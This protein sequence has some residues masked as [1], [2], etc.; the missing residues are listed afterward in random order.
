MNF[1]NP[2]QL[3]HTMKK[4]IHVLLGIA[5]A[6]FVSCDSRKGTYWDTGLSFE[7]R[8]ADLVGRMTLGEKV[9]QLVH[10]A[11]AIERLGVPA[12]N[13][14]NESLHGVAR[15]GVA[16]VF[17]QAIGMAAMWDGEG[18][19]RIADAIS[20]EARAKYQDY[21]SRG[22][23]GIYQG[24][25]FWTPNLNIFR[26]PRWG[27]GMETYGEDPYLTGELGV[28]FIRGMQGDD[29][30]YLKIIATAKH[31]TVHSGPESTRHSADVYP[32]D[33]DLAETFLPHFKRAVQDARVY[34]V[35]C[36]Y[37]R[38]RGLPC[39]GSEFLEDILR[40][41]WAFEGYIVSD[42]W[43]IR[44][45]YQENQHHVVNTPPEAAAMALHAGTDLNCGPT[46]AH[47]VEA[48]KQGLVTEQ[49]IDTAVRRVML[50]RMKVG[51]FDPDDMVP[52]TRIPID[53][54]DSEE[55]RQLALEATRKS[56]VLLRNENNL[57]P[58]T[59]QV[60]KVAV[61]GPNANDVEVMI[62]NY[63][64]FPSNPVTPLEGIR[65]KLPNAGVGFAQGA[66][67][68]ENLP[69]LEV[70]PT[71]CLYTDA[72]K[73]Q[74]GLSAEFFNNSNWEGEAAHT[75]ID[76]QISFDWWTTPPYPEMAYDSYSIRWTGVL[77]PPV[78][79]EYA[80]GA[81][82]F[83]GYRVFLDG[84]MIKDWDYG[85][86]S[87]NQYFTMM[88]KQFGR[89]SLEGGRAYELRVEYKQQNSEYAM[90]RL[91]WEPPKPNLMQEALELA[92]ASDLVILCLG[93]SPL[94]EGEAMEMEVEGFRGGDK[95]DIQLPKTQRA[96]VR[97]I[98]KLGKPTVLVLLNGSPVALNW[99]NEHI[100][101]IIEA[102]YPGQAGGTAIAD[103]IFGDYNPSGK[104]PVT[105]YKSVDQIPAFDNYDM[106]GKTYRY[107]SGEPLYEFGYGLSYTTFEYKVKEVPA[108]VRTGDAFTVSVE[109]TNTG[110]MDGE[111]IVQLY[112][113]LTDSPMRKPI[114]ALQGFRRVNL[115]AG[116]TKSVEFTLTPAQL[117]GRDEANLAVETPGRIDL[118]V[119]G[120]QPDPQALQRRQVV[121][122][123]VN[124]T[125]NLFYIPE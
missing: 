26:D 104:L 83:T 116:E 107:F 45:F 47:L 125:G 92:K 5:L 6:A 111:E 41:Q 50:A 115:K 119:G 118:F 49:E 16:T 56:L 99:E 86:S 76:P 25:S 34:S 114:R 29:P 17:P 88:R 1:R 23:R 43:A 120:K 66:A 8:T 98:Q 53:V 67:L 64:G 109:V 21:S 108:E 77:V 113:T 89:L 12:H 62:G 70:I 101:A 61:I 103:V 121:A 7:E 4:A 22:K 38:L 28:Q 87:Q 54:V 122:A 33:Y 68:V 52:Y 105:F 106:Q 96:L 81:D 90:M 15:S 91:L 85:R 117:A 69:W 14:W 60:K 123:A 55:H 94:L 74:H 79:G 42:C 20:D 80:L 2:N 97:E 63:N 13:W 9:S 73:R 84:R 58:F 51:Q 95:L 10:D 18:M 65:R 124:L 40:R 78:S 32:S 24:L 100:P 48:L 112:V 57:L 30:K 35:M 82:A 37:Q 102:W 3:N 44:D 19:L 11:P 31:F 46:Y 27:R 71:D 39:C 59:K 36:A 72:T 93:L 110:A 75:R